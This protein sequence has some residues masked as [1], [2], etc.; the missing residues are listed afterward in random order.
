[1]SGM[2]I[3]LI[4]YIDQ[5]H[6]RE[7][8]PQKT[9]ILHW[10]QNYK[11]SFWFLFVLSLYTFGLYVTESLNNCY[12]FVSRTSHPVLSLWDLGKQESSQKIWFLTQ[13]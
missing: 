7:I 9:D 8:Q 10:S 2:F 3:V 5:S 13:A 1:M 4:Y 6:V 12:P 11:F